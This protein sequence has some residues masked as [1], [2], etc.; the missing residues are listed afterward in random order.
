MGSLGVAAIDWSVGAVTVRT[1]V[2]ETPSVAVTGEVPADMAVAR[3]VA[4]I[5]AVAVT[6]DDQGCL[7][8]QVL[9]GVIAVSA[10]RDELL[11][12]ALRDRQIRGG[13]GD[14]LQGGGGDSEHGGACNSQRRADGACA[15]SGG[16][17]EAGGADRRSRGGMDDQVT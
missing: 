12:Q 2:P 14:R 7:T 13:Y 1:V 4:L 5:V 3:P 8:G 15:D 17:G 10:G 16:G 11:G 6:P 9:R